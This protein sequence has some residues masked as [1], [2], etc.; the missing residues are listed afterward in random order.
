MRM[1]TPMLTSASSRYVPLSDQKRACRGFEEVE[2]ADG[3]QQQ[4]HRQQQI[5]QHG[6]DDDTQRD[7]RQ[8]GQL[9][10]EQLQPPDAAREDA[11]GWCRRNTP[12]RSAA[13]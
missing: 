1:V 12:C 8:R 2:I 11:R 10:E 7:E 13:P 6:D 9:A 4:E 5:E 3:E